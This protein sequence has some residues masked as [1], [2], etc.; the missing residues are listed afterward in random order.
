[1]RPTPRWLA[2]IAVRTWMK[3]AVVTVRPDAPVGD[4]AALMRRKKIRH[5]P[6]VAGGGGLVG[7][8]TDRDL[9]QV[10]FDPAILEGADPGG[11]LET[12][13]VREIMTWGVVTVRPGTDIREAAFLMHERKIGALP[14][15]VG[16]RVVGILSERDV[17]RALEEVLRS[18]VTTVRPLVERAAGEDYEYGFAPPASGAEEGG[19]PG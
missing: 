10:I 3:S 2:P 1:M 12:L 19:A 17:L 5:L 14:V 18:H 15:V 4:A 16:G 11:A 6:V 9:R 7:I 8:V 13:T